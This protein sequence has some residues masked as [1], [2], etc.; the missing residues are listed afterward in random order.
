MATRFRDSAD[1]VGADVVADRDRVGGQPVAN[2]RARLQRL[3]ARVG[4]L[5]PDGGAERVR[6][7]RRASR[8][9]DDAGPI[10][11][12]VLEAAGGVRVDDVAEL[13]VDPGD[14]PGD[15]GIGGAGGAERGCGLQQVP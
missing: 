5:E 15:L 9:E 13:A 6:E 2:D 11:G 7:L 4:R 8:G 14:E 1:C 10:G 3:K 12:E